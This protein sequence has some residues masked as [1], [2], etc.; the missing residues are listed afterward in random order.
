MVHTIDTYFTP[1]RELIDGKTTLNSSEINRLESLLSK[2]STWIVAEQKIK[3]FF[4]EKFLEYVD[5]HPED[6]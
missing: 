4:Y 2:A 5:D 1:I 6:W 3:D